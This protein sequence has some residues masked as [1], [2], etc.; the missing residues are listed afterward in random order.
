MITKEKFDSEKTSPLISAVKDLNTALEEAHADKVELNVIGGFAM[1]MN[2]V[3]DK[4]AMTDI[5]YVGIPLPEKIQNL[6]DKIG[7]KHGLPAGWLNN[8]TM[9]TDS[10]IEDFEFSSG[11][12]NYAESI[13]LGNIK[14]NVA[15]KET[16]LRLKTISIDTA[17][18]GIEA[19]GDFTR[20]KDFKDIKALMN[21]LG[22]TTKDLKKDYG[23]YILNENTIP[24]IDTYLERGLDAALDKIEDIGEKGQKEQDN[25][26]ADI[27]DEVNRESSE[28][29]HSLMDMFLDNAVERADKEDIKLAHT[30]FEEDL[31][32]LY[33]KMHISS[34]LKQTEAK[35]RPPAKHTKKKDDWN[36]GED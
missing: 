5:D 4:D 36:I 14:I 32:I 8:D 31:Q 33:G 21:D 17:A 15:D 26:W 9:V 3:R 12:L 7:E 10:S 1:I 23:D 11:K 30:S 20:T 35:D 18:M 19:T 24:L 25:F 34:S 16:L 22:K 6:S 28:N 29:F 13:D 27:S 2:E